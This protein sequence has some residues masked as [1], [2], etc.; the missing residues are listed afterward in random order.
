MGLEVREG[1]SEIGSV[2]GTGCE[3]G[4]ALLAL[5]MEKAT[6]QETE[7]K[8]PLGAEHGPWLIASKERGTSALQPQEAEF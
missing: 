3:E 5:T 2:G 6:G 7:W 8:W 4:S 1:K